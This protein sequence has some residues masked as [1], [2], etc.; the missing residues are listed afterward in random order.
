MDKTEYT[1]FPNVEPDSD[2]IHWLGKGGPVRLERE[3]GVDVPYV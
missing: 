3:P 1:E 2:Y